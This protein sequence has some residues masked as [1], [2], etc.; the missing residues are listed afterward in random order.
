MK[1]IFIWVAC[2]ATLL[3][4]FIVKLLKQAPFEVCKVNLPFDTSVT[5]KIKIPKSYDRP[6]RLRFEALQLTYGKSLPTDKIQIYIRNE[7]VIP[8]TFYI[9]PTLGETVINQYDEIKI[10]DGA[11]DDFLIAGR[12]PQEEFTI[13][14]TK[15]RTVNAKIRFVC[16]SHYKNLEVSVLAWSPTFSF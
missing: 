8:L 2:F 9:G 14:S 6:W 3:G 11:I 4:W 1:N 13:V 15:D 10:F 12:K 7:D 16:K 5:A